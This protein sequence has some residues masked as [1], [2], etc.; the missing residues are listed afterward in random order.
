MAVMGRCALPDCQC[1]IMDGK[2]IAVSIEDGQSHIM[3]FQIIS[4]TTKPLASAGRIATEGHC[5]VLD[6]D[7]AYIGD[8]ERGRRAV[9]QE[10]QCVPHEGPAHAKERRRPLMGVTTRVEVDVLGMSGLTWQEV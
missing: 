8:K 3:A 10:M 4:P 9:V 6:D 5:S 2:R 1:A 7:D